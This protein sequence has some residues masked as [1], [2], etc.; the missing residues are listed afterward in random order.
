MVHRCLQSSEIG[1]APRNP[2][3]VP[4]NAVAALPDDER[5]WFASLRSRSRIWLLFDSIA[6]TTIAS[7]FWAVL[8]I[9]RFPMKKGRTEFH[10]V[11]LS[12]DLL[13]SPLHWA[14]PKVTNRQI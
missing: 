7:A 14:C 12:Q 4:A 11:L 6:A 13:T 3:G 2:Y 5:E 9:N 8:G 1:A 10:T